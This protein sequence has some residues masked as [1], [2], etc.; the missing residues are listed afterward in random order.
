[1]SEK[2]IYVTQ[3]DMDRLR[4]LTESGPPYL[5]KIRDRISVLQKELDRAVVVEPEEMPADIVT[6]HSRVHFTRLDSG[7]ASI[8]ELVFPSEANIKENKISVLAPVGIALLG[9]GVGDVIE[10]VIPSGKARLKIEKIVYQPEA[11]GEYNR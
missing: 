4:T 6:M 10:W 8:Y 3:F 2:A 9:Q 1:M 5:E 7:E 11:A